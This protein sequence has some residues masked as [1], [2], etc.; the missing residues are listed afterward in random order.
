MGKGIEV[1]Q[2]YSGGRFSE[3]ALP[4]GGDAVGNGVQGCNGSGGEVRRGWVGGAT[5][6]KEMQRI[7]V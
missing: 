6:G 3:V 1:G 4:L 7:G 2:G 5:V